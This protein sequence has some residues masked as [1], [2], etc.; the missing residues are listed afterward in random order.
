MKQVTYCMH[1][2]K[3]QLIMKGLTQFY[4]FNWDG[5]ANGKTFMTIG[6]KPYDDYET[7]AHLGTKVEC[8][9]SSDKTP[10]KFKDGE[11]FSNRFEKI[12]FKVNKDIDIPLDAKVIPKGVTA[13]VYGEYRNQLSVKCDDI[14]IL[15][16]TPV[17]K[18]TK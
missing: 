14:E 5:F 15:P 13:N 18:L 7:K 1:Y 10:Y 16:A 3:G 11:V 8:V 2:K 9:I 6:C 12:V 4:S 17:T